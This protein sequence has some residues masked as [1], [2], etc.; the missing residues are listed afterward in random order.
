VLQRIGFNF[1]AQVPFESNIEALK[2]YK[3]KRGHMRVSPKEDKVLHTFILSIRQSMTRM[4]AGKCPQIRLTPDRMKMLHQIDFPFVRLQ[5]CPFGSCFEALKLY[6]AKHGHIRVSAEEDKSL[7]KFIATLRLSLSRIQ[8]GKT[9][10][11]DLTPDRIAALE[12]IGFSCKPKKRHCTSVSGTPS[13]NSNSF[14]R[15]RVEERLHENHEEI[16]ISGALNDTNKDEDMEE[17][18]GDI[19][20]S[21]LINH[22]EEEDK[23]N[24]LDDE[25]S[26]VIDVE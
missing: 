16:T 26:I 2:L 25:N 10:P 8:K 21:W 13:T 15:Q 19:I 12:V 20:P 1:K 22:E 5:V 23:G 14:K 24:G 9:P 3:A 6:Q 7:N 17:I 4:E 11:L 18:E